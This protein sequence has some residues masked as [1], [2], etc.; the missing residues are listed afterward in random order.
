MVTTSESPSSGFLYSHQFQSDQSK[1]LKI[2]ILQYLSCHPNKLPDLIQH[3]SL[4]VHDLIGKV[5]K[6]LDG[7]DVG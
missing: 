3:N 5:S 1:F 6:F 4:L 2:Q 7:R